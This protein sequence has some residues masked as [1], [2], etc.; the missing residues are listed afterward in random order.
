MKSYGPLYG[1][2]LKYWHRNVLPVIEVGTTQETER[3]YRLG[4]C[5]VLRVPFTHPGFYFGLWLKRP[6]IDLDDEDS[7]DALLFRTMRGRK[8][9]S[10]Q[11]GLFDEAFFSE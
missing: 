7:I 9:W 2:K 1:G 3:P 8:A 5:L 11:D 4:K 10:P 6:N